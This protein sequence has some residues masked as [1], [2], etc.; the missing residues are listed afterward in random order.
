MRRT[1]VFIFLAAVA[2]LS[3]GVSAGDD[4]YTAMLGYLTNGSLDG[5]VLQGAEGSVAV[6]LAAG[7]LSSQADLYA[8]ATAQD[9]QVWI[10]A[11]QR[12]L[13]NHATAPLEAQATI[14]GNALAGADELVSV[15]QSSGTAR[16]QINAVA[17]DGT[18][19][20]RGVPQVNRTTVSGS[21]KG[22]VLSLSV[23]E[24]PR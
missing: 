16:T 12:T 11:R 14:A 8:F 3:T 1:P 22:N 7:D 21:A 4:D 10:D 20:L 9:A 18:R 19:G 13:G 23:S 15:N 24:L 17:A 6:N 2:V 5:H